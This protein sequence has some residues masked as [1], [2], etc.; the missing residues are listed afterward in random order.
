MKGAKRFKMQGNLSHPFIGP[1]DFVGYFGKV[2]YELVLL[3]DL[4]AVHQV[5]HVSLLKKCI[6]DP[7][8]VFP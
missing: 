2:V 7:A 4:E 5:F 6:S 1:Y 3:E 8:L